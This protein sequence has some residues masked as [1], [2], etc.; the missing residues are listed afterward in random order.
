MAIGASSS[1][2]YGTRIVES[3][4]CQDLA[5]QVDIL[6]KASDVSLATISVNVREKDDFRVHHFIVE[7]QGTTSPV[8]AARACGEGLVGDG[9]GD[10]P[11]TRRLSACGGCKV[12]TFKPHHVQKVVGNAELCHRGTTQRRGR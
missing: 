2:S 11:R 5:E 12:H 4:L 3:L 9:I 8:T 1:T 7:E 10:C 6:L